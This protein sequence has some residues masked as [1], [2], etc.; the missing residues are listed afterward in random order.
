[1]WVPQA[2]SPSSDTCSFLSSRTPSNA[3]VGTDVC[4]PP[5]LPPLPSAKGHIQWPREPFG[6]SGTAQPPCHKEIS[7]PGPRAPSPQSQPIFPR[8]GAQLPGGGSFTGLRYFLQ[9]GFSRASHL[10]QFPDIFKDLMSTRDYLAQG[11]LHTLVHACHSWK[12]TAVAHQPREKPP[13]C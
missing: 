7:H 4:H 3:P 2:H 10:N 5:C 9:S 13:L 8:P 11:V 12:S 1:M 6:T